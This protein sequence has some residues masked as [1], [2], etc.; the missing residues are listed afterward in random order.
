M[1]NKNSRKKKGKKD[2]TIDDLIPLDLIMWVGRKF[3][4]IESFIEEAK[5]LGVCKRIG[6]GLPYSV[7]IGKSRVF[8]VHDLSDLEKKQGKPGIPRIFAY[9]VIRGILVVGNPKTIAQREGINIT[10]I[11]EA[12]ISSFPKRGC[13]QLR[14]NGIYLVSEEDLEKLKG[15]ASGVEGQIEVLETPIPVSFKRFRAFK[16]V[17]GDRI[18]SGQ[19]EETWFDKNEINRILKHN[20]KV[21]KAL[22]RKWLVKHPE[23]K[24]PKKEPYWKMVLRL[25]ATHDKLLLRDTITALV[26]LNPT[27][28]SNPRGVYRNVITKLARKGFLKLYKFNNQIFV[29]RNVDVS[30]IKK[31]LGEETNESS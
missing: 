23:V 17:L 25:F 8:L 5:R 1:G 10:V 4:T 24:K 11:D 21:A 13:G 27:S 30:T 15:Y 9:F 29:E 3:Y 19:P 2:Y 28:S 22:R 7:V 20:Y 12:K 14:V 18:L 31:A 16:Y 6:G 26:A